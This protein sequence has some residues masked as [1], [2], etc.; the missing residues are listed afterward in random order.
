MKCD[1]PEIR[2]YNAYTYKNTL[3]LLSKAYLDMDNLLFKS[4]TSNS[5][6]FYNEYLIS[7]CEFATNSFAITV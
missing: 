4:Q 6:K 3:S 2:S 1:V 7:G 5:M